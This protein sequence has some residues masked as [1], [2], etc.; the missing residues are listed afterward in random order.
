M[1]NA[2]HF[3]INQQGVTVCNHWRTQNTESRPDLRNAQLDGA[4]QV[5]V[6]LR[7]GNL[8]EASLVGA[9]LSNAKFS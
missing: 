1:P 4:E 6:N 8:S 5:G 9:H 7:E 2:E 3:E